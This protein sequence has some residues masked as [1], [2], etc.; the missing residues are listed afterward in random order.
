MVDNKPCKINAL[1]ASLDYT[2]F[3]CSILVWK[4][5]EKYHCNIGVM[6][7]FIARH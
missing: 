2:V 6:Q 3:S 5:D 1:N 4:Q 7:T